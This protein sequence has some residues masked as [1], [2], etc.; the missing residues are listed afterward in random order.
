VVDFRATR[1]VAI[2][3]RIAWFPRLEGERFQ[4]QGGQ[5][6]ELG[7]GVR[8]D[9]LQ[10]GRLTGSFTMLPGLV[11]FSATRTSI[12]ASRGVTSATYPTLQL[13]GSLTFD[14]SSRVFLVADAGFR[15]QP[16]QGSDAGNFLMPAGVNSAWRVDW[17]GG[18]RFG[19]PVADTSATT[20]QRTGWTLGAALNYSVVASPYGLATL[21]QSAGIGGFVSRRLTN[22]MDVEAGVQF[23]PR[24]EVTTAF[25]G[26]RLIQAA[27]SLKVG[28]R[29]RHIGV[30][31]RGGPEFSSYSQV[32]R[33][34]DDTGPGY[35]IFTFSR[36]TYPTLDWGGVIEYYPSPRVVVRVDLSSVH[37]FY[38]SVVFITD[39]VAIPLGSSDFPAVADS[40]HVI[41]R[42]GWRF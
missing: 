33:S 39:G 25:D 40:V 29:G 34:A 7:A 2:E 26:G 19:A 36:G 38:R 9:L 23:F 22:W 21:E 11:R 16:F 27:V 1:R 12:L 42:M 15:F 6:A 10:I 30:F 32:M 17:G 31:A 24:A 4:T 8:A 13:V 5:T 14:L 35:P 3:V 18:Y 41:F 20:P 37:T 28:V